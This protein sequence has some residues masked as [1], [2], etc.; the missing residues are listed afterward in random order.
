M[1]LS[2]SQMFFV[3]NEFVIF[4]F[5]IF[6]KIFSNE[7]QKTVCCEKMFCFPIYV[8]ENLCFISIQGF[9]FLASFSR[10]NKF[11][12]FEILLKLK[13]LISFVPY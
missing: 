12:N 9:L 7:N 13:M 10:K 11:Q 1:I 6:L 5:L 3:K 2:F 4:L 8:N